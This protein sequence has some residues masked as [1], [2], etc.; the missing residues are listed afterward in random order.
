[1]IHLNKWSFG[2]AIL[3]LVSC[4]SQG[5]QAAPFNPTTA[6]ELQAALDS[7]Q[8]NGEDD[9]ITLAANTTYSTADNGNEAFEYKAD[10]AENKTLT[11]QGAGDGTTILDGNGSSPILILATPTGP[12]TDDSSAHVTVSGVTIIDGQSPAHIT[13]TAADIHVDNLEAF[14]NL[15]SFPLTTKDGDITLSSSLFTNNYSL[16]VNLDS[17]TGNISVHENEFRG[18][19]YMPFV[20]MATNETGNVVITGNILAD[21]SGGVAGNGALMGA[22][23]QGTITLTNNTIVNNVSTTQVGGVYLAF[24]DPSGS[25]R[26]YNN[27]IFGNKVLM[28]S[29]TS[30]QDIYLQDVPCTLP[31]SGNT[32]TIS[33][34]DYSDLLS[35]CREDSDCSPNITET[36]NK[37]EDPLFIDPSNWDFHLGPGSPCLGA[38]DP[39]A[40]EIPSTDLEGRPLSNPPDMGALAAKMALVVDPTTIDYGRT[41]TEVPRAVAVT[42]TNVGGLGLNVTDIALSDTDNYSIGFGTCGSSSFTIADGESCSIEITFGPKSNGTFDATATITSDDPDNPTRV[43]NLTGIGVSTGGGGCSLIAR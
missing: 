34:N 27:I 28:F 35:T 38:G 2:L 13:T 40:P 42:L 22:T 15:H 24:S 20:L 3:A 21:N 31:C 36:A 41:S 32:I 7:A 19:D 33:N 8:V 30:A 23:E 6:A 12:G 43:I 26:L 4:F 9:V 25:G 10:A 11:I 37:N 5:L 17:D 16:M 39:N 1:M 18:N 14:G 29:P